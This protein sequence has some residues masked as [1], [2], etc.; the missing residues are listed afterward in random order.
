MLTIFSTPKPFQGHIGVIQRSALKSWTLLHP[1]IEVILF[2]DDDGAAD[3]CHELRFRH[4]PYV[5]RGS[6]GMNV[7]TTC[8]VR[9]RRSPATIFSA[10]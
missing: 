2:G 5:E 3:V 1:D 8:S 7:S 10:M 4:E 6:S 9:L